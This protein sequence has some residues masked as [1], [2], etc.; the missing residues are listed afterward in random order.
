VTQHMPREPHEG[1]KADTDP[2]AAALEHDQ[3]S[4]VARRG[5]SRGVVNSGPQP[6]DEQPSQTVSGG[7]ASGGPLAGVSADA[8]DVRNAVGGDTGPT[9]PGRQ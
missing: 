2:K 9:R 6:G 8:E 5:Q 3:S 1:I 4:Y 7:T